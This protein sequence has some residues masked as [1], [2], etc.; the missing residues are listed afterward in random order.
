MIGDT[1]GVGA[2]DHADDLLGILDVF[3]LDNL[4]ILDDVERDVGRYYAETTYLL[5]GQITV[6]YL[7]DALFAQ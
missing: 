1:L 4:V 7:D 5:I 2:L 3:L 6:G